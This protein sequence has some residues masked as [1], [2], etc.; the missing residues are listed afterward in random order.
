M[1]TVMTASGA[2]RKFQSQHVDGSRYRQSTNRRRSMRI[3]IEDVAPHLAECPRVN[4]RGITWPLTHSC[5]SWR[6][7]ADDPR[8][9][10]V[11]FSTPAR[12]ALEELELGD[13]SLDPAV[14]SRAG[15]AIR[16]LI[17]VTLRRA[18]TMQRNKVH[19]VTVISAVARQLGVEQDLLHEISGIAPVR[20]ALRDVELG[21]LLRA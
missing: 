2:T 11:E 5:S 15:S 10:H 9:K 8:L 7:R 3:I 6:S 16:R 1:R 20:A 13:M 19:S 14:C 18:P 21:G 4:T 17:T 12:L